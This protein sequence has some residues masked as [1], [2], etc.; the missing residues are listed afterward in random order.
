MV[1]ELLQE[2]LFV[3]KE[4]AR[5]LK[6]F[7]SELWLS[8]ELPSAEAAALRK[9]NSKNVEEIKELLRTA[10]LEEV[11]HEIYESAYVLQKQTKVPAI[12][13]KARKIV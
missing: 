13:I 8:W 4:A 2:P 1:L 11:S 6:D 3:L 12:F 9:G 10:G 5:L 7:G